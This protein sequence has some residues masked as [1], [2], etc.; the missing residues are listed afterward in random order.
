MAVKVPEKYWSYQGHQ[1]SIP[2][3]SSLWVCSEPV[4]KSSHHAVL[5]PPLNLGSTVKVS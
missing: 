4:Q 5:D 3:T 2:L 1:V